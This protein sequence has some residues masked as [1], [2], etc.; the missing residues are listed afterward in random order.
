MNKVADNTAMK[1][2]MSL[3]SYSPINLPRT[4]SPEE[5]ARIEAAKQK[6]FPKIMKSPGDPI[7]A[8]M[9]SPLKQALMAAA[10]GGLVG[11]GGAHMMGADTKYEVI[12]GLTTAAL[13]AMLAYVLR[14]NKNEKLEDVSLRLPAKATRRDY[15]LNPVMQVEE[16]GSD[17][18]KRIAML[19]AA[20]RGNYKEGSE[21]EAVGFRGPEL[22]DSKPTGS[23]TG[24]Q[25]DTIVSNS[26]GFLGAEVPSMDRQMRM[27]ALAETEGMMNL[28]KHPTNF[29]EALKTH[30]LAGANKDI[31]TTNALGPIIQSRDQYAFNSANSGGGILDMLMKTIG[32]WIGNQPQP[33]V[34]KKSLIG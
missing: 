6:L 15:E 32:S 24:I 17:A 2:M 34:P 7:S 1:G 14:Q 30:I 25:G 3:K 22:T 29:T 8:D 20:I 11:A 18:A 27:R 23:Y 26:P 21:K 4:P 31:A 12:S 28:A 13:A 33:Q 19:H 16:D 5:A 10:G 9:A